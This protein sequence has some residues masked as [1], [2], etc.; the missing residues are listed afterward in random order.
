[1]THN[2]LIAGSFYHGNPL[3]YKGADVCHANG[4]SMCELYFKLLKESCI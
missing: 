2:L 4:K 1:M 3:M